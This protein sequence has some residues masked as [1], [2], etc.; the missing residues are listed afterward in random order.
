ML[1]PEGM[2][3]VLIAATKSQ[4]EPVI[5]EIYR[6]NLFHIEEFVEKDRKEYEGYRIGTPLPQANE[7]S[8]ELLR[9]RGITNAFMIREDEEGIP[10]EK[11]K[12]EHLKGLIG[13][14]LPAL[15]KDVEELLARRT[16]LDTQIKEYE[17]KIEGL[18]PFQ[19]IPVDLELLRGYRSFSVFSGYISRELHLDIPHEIYTAESK[20]AKLITLVVSNSD[21]SAAEQA[22]ADAQ[23][24]AVPIPDEEGIAKDRIGYYESQLLAVKG[25]LEEINR[26][27]DEI[28]KEHKG[29]FLAC[30]ELLTAD[31]EMAEAP[32]RFATIGESFIVEGWVPKS[33]LE[34]FRQG[35]HY[36]TGGKVYVYEMDPSEVEDVAPTE[37]HNVSFAKPTE[38]LMDV[39]SRPK[40][41]EIDPTLLV[42]IIFPIFFGIILGDVGYGAIVLALS[43]GL[44]K[45]ITGDEGTRL[46]KVLRNA[47]ISSIVFGV[48]Y[49]ECFGFALPWKPILFSRHLNIGGHAG[50]HGPDVISLMIMAV[51][52]GILQITLGRILGMINHARQDHGAHRMKAV[53]ANLGWIMVLW[54]IL[55]MLWAA[56]TMPFMPDFTGLPP[57]AMGLNIASI[58]GIV[59]I[60]L[61]VIFIIR[62]SALE[63]VE[64]PTILSHVLSYARLVG[65]GLSSVAIA[66]VVNFIAIGLIIEPQLESL[67]AVGVIIIIVGVLVFVIGH[68]LNTILGV[69]GGALQSIRLQYVEFFTKFYKGGGKKYNPFGMKKRFTED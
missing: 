47:S 54:G 63:I 60:I 61:G 58:I 27:L 12:N 30:N 26:R 67:S 9:L 31:V 4:M 46:L 11:Q 32:L 6:Q 36:A 39:Y 3:R 45:I 13:K 14:E 59:M 40:Y 51:W 17:Q 48:L 53:M 18:K 2:T 22:L 21:R 28:K 55:F 49:S 1:T 38:M 10:H 15:E 35:I 41:T 52:I 56:F 7:T 25:E 68:L 20:K 43:L 23:F 65:V 66:M 50:G 37:Y 24:Q 69:L 42:S 62:D 44:R 33:E 29:L 5:R 57:I 64:L 19:D 8:R 34:K 16:R